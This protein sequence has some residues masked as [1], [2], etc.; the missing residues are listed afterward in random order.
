MNKWKVVKDNIENE[1]PHFV[2][3]ANGDMSL[4]PDSPAYTIPGFEPIPFDQIGI[5]PE[6]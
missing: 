3:E 5:L 2:D 4:A 1:D 6:H